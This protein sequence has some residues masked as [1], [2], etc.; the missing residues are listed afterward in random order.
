MY[1]KSTAAP[2]ASSR[3]HSS[4][5][6]F[7]G[8]A[9]QPNP[10]ARLRTRPRNPSGPRRSPLRTRLRWSPLG[11]RQLSLACA[12]TKPQAPHPIKGER[13]VVRAPKPA[14]RL[15]QHRRRAD[16]RSTKADRRRPSFDSGRS[17]PSPL[18]VSTSLSSPR[19]TLLIPLFIRARSRSNRRRRRRPEPPCAC[20]GSIQR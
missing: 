10:P 1:P 9:Q 17:R 18:S 16:P 8:R 19:S 14:A 6:R 2:L 7:S 12:P 13:R 11:H 20:A 5:L 3:G 15:R 4:T